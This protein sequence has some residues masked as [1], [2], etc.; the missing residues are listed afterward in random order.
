MLTGAPF[1]MYLGGLLLGL[2]AGFYM[3]R[4][5]YCVVGMFRDLFLLREIGM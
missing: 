4:S 1:F 3:H 2:V 5:D